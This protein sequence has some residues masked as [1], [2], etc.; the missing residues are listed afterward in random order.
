MEIV[1]DFMKERQHQIVQDF[2]KNAPEWEAID[3]S[4][5]ELQDAEKGFLEMK[6]SLEVEDQVNLK[7]NIKK[8][9]ML[10]ILRLVLKLKFFMT[11]F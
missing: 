2:E 1:D 5:M 3:K 6:E 11:I 8:N 4:F 9:E 10:A 7:I